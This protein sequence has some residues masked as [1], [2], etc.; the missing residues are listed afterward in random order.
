[1]HGLLDTLRSLPRKGAIMS[2]RQAHARPLSAR[3]VAACLVAVMQACMFTGSV[4]A[5]PAPRDFDVRTDPAFAAMATPVA[6]YVRTSGRAQR[7]NRI[8]ILGEQAAD[9]SRSA[10]V[11][12]RRAHRIV[13][14][15]PGTNDLASSRRI[16]DLRKDVVASDRDLRGS[17]YR[18]TRPWVEQLV[19]RCAH[20]GAHLDIR[21]SSIR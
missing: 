19:A 21:L 4:S 11:I 2:C 14:W 3:P 6:R 9:G 15:E 17:T 16:L 1:M 13:L 8:C 20:S 7:H 12:W 18:V 5:Q 10:W